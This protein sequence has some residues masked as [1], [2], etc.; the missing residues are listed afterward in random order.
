M[1]DIFT[2]GKRSAIMARIRAKGNRS[3][4]L[5][6]LTLLR[7]QRITGWRRHLPLPGRPDF[8]F[9]KLRLAVFLDGCFWHGCPA[10]GVQPKTNST[11][12]RTK[13]V[14]NR[15]RDFAVARQLRA[16]GWRVV[17]FWEHELRTSRLPGA[18]AKLDRALKS[19]MAAAG[20]PRRRPLRR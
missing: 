19:R 20:D 6:F 16:S 8:A 10:H 12:W 13:I 5:Q 14:K 2:K 4:E 9:P 18:L 1:A 17:R 15:A 3:T 7:T 11:F